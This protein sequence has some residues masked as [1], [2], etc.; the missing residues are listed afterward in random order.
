MDIT[1]HPATSIFFSRPWS[2]LP[3]KSVEY[4]RD[5]ITNGWMGASGVAGVVE[6]GEVISR[7]GLCECGS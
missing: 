6:I 2:F 1:N 3:G 7:D 4:V 5:L